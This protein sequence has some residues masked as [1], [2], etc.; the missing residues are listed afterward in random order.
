MAEYTPRLNSDGMQG[1]P[2]WYSDNP[3]YQSGYGLPNCTCYAWGRWYEISGVRPNLCTGNAE[4]WWNYND[5]YERGSTPQLGA[6]ICL[7]NGPY[8]GLGHVAVVEEINGDNITFS[9]SA[10][11]GGYF[12]LK[13]GTAANGYGYSEYNFQGF[14]YNPEEPIPPIPPTPARKHKKLPIYMYGRNWYK[15]SIGRR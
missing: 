13:T 11:G 9:N 7:A 6:I 3:F 12:Y 5:G 15:R 4:E 1:N 2:Y 10:Y 14:I 8:S